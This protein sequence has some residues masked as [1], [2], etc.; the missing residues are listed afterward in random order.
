MIKWLYLLLLSTQIYS[1]YAE[2][3]ATA[4]G[5][6]KT[7]EEAPDATEEVAETVGPEVE[8][9]RIDEEKTTGNNTEILI[10]EQ[11]AMENITSEDEPA[12]EEPKN[13]TEEEFPDNKQTDVLGK[14]IKKIDA[15]FR[16]GEINETDVSDVIDERKNFRKQKTDQEETRRKLKKMRA[17]ALANVRKQL[18]RKK[19]VGRT[20]DKTSS[21]KPS[22]HLIFLVQTFLCLLFIYNTK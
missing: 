3:E 10:P 9:T 5:E 11:E 14:D 4:E 2:E 6:E 17:R 13:I 16:S 12:S 1:G 8:T 19:G 18:T 21:N 7:S 20:K 15:K 22:R